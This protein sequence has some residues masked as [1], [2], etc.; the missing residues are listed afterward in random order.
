M[1]QDV[2]QNKV[3]HPIAWLEGQWCVAKHLR[4]FANFC[5]WQGAPGASGLGG[6]G[7]PSWYTSFTEKYSNHHL[8]KA[9][10]ILRFVQVPYHCCHEREE[11]KHSTKT[12]RHGYLDTTARELQPWSGWRWDEPGFSNQS[13]N[14]D[15]GV[16]PLPAE[17]EPTSK[18]LI[19]VRLS[20]TSSMYAVDNYN[21]VRSILT[22]ILIDMIFA[23][24]SLNTPLL[25]FKS[26]PNLA[27]LSMW[28][29][30]IHP[31]QFILPPRNIKRR[32]TANMAVKRRHRCHLSSGLL[33][34]ASNFQ[35]SMVV[36][37]SLCEEADTT[38]NGI[39]CGY[40]YMYTFH[41]YVYKYQICVWKY[42]H[43]FYREWSTTNP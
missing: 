10:P 30:H 6:N 40:L 43:M 36:L 9:L 23:H 5:N 38:L 42:M 35:Q 19:F 21:T 25:L 24:I 28:N 32:Y 8:K 39:T 4:G 1:F 13:P 17:P 18:S 3:H 20:P 22:N 2:K 16:S 31:F 41:K 29:H 12:R 14:A 26:T 34:Q 33:R 27:N 37:G 7:W 15:K 11:K